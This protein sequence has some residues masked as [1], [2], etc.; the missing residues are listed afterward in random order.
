MTGVSCGLLHAAVDDDRSFTMGDYEG[1]SADFQRLVGEYAD[2]AP[3]SDGAGMLV[4][5]LFRA[6]QF[7]ETD[8]A[9]AAMVENWP[10]SALLISNGLSFNRSSSGAPPSFLT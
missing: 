4:E 10:Q 5:S 8:G 3:A 6:G 2:S 1:A 9:F 7:D